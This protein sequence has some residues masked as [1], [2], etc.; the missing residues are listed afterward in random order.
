MKM[1][2]LYYVYLACC[3]NGSVYTGHTR[4]VE[5]RMVEHN[6]GRGGRYTRTNRPLKLL[7]F[8][9]FSSKIQAIRAERT[10]K[11]LPPEQKLALLKTKSVDELELLCQF[12]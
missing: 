10:I 2:E 5:R 6:A 11:T 1:S 4:N 9:I 12:S 3:A 8:W 7:G